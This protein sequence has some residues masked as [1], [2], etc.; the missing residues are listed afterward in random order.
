MERK[1]DDFGAALDVQIGADSTI[2]LIG[3]AC[4]AYP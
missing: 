2:A 1:I 3:G 4:S